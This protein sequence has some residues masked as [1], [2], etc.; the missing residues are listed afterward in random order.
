MPRPA[1]LS[2]MTVKGISVSSTRQLTVGMMKELVRWGTPWKPSSRNGTSNSRFRSLWGAAGWAGVGSAGES[3]RRKRLCWH[4]LLNKPTSTTAVNKRQEQAES[5]Q[6]ASW[7]PL[8]HNPSGGGGGG[9]RSDG[10]SGSGTDG[11][12]GSGGNSS[13]GTDGSSSSDSSSGREY[14]QVHQLETHP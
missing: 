9:S 2:V 13:S 14:Q 3:G 10:S 12:S 7:P 8:A 1:P 4:L 5:R 11:S 6:P